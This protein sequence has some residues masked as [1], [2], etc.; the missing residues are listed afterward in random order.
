PRER[1]RLYLFEDLQHDPQGL[2]RGLF[3]F[4]DVDPTFVPDL[5]QRHNTSGGVIGNPVL[6]EAW[7]RT[8]LLRARVRRH[9]P[10]RIR[11][12]AFGLVTRKLSA[13]QLD[14]EMRRELTELYH[15][16]VGQLAALVGRD[17]SHWLSPLEG[18]MDV[19]HPA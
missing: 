6:R 2:L 4:L 11:D 5:E 17:L 18:H 8:A 12:S 13:V 19:A 9:I 16:E 3:T 1:I 10:R 7:T 15:G 14:P